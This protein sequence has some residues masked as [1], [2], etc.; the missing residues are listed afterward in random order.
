[1][2]SARMPSSAGCFGCLTPLGWLNRMT[3]FKEKAG[4][5]RDDRR[6]RA[7]RLSGADGGRHPR[8]TRRRTCRSAR[9][10]S[11][12]SNWRATSPAP[13]TGATSVDFFPLPEPQIFGDGDAGDEPA[14]RHQEDVE[15]RH[16]GLFAHQHDR[17]CRR[18]RAEDPPRQ[19]RPRA[20]AGDRSRRSK[21]GPRPTT[22]SASTPRS[23]TMTR[24]AALAQ[25]RR[26][27]FLDLQGGIVRGS[28]SRCSAGSAARCAG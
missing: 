28:R 2:V 4:K 20:A 7:L 11:S 23:P 18:D 8:S 12:I 22:S 10:R 1:M 14:R 5:Q 3:Q 27:E 9:T 21:R 19:D 13:S 25:L 26:A 16:L 6:A 24:E 15:I 17:R